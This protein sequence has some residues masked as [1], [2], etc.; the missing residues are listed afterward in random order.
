MGRVILLS[1]CVF[2]LSPVGLSGITFISIIPF[3][4]SCLGD[5]TQNITLIS[6]TSIAIQLFSFVYAVG[7]VFPWNAWKAGLFY[8]Y[9]PTW[10]IQTIGTYCV[11]SSI[12]TNTWRQHIIL[13]L[14][15]CVN[16]V[17]VWKN[18]I[19]CEKFDVFFYLSKLLKQTWSEI[20]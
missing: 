9:K 13:I 1:C 6:Y 17:Q 4:M 14:L 20:S 3:E 12:F 16:K 10:E 2:L 18:C 19:D 15:D 8:M 7:L 5:S 11:R